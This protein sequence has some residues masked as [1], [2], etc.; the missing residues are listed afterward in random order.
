MGVVIPIVAGLGVL[1]SVT[2]LVLGWHREPAGEALLDN[3]LA[4]VQ[5]RIPCWLDDPMYASLGHVSPDWLSHI[6]R[7]S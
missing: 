1:G 6:K 4:P 5:D 7:T 3:T 2:A